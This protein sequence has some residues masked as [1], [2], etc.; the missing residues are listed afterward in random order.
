MNAMSATLD[1]GDFDPLDAFEAEKKGIWTAHVVLAD[2]RRFR[3]TFYDPA[4]LAQD[5][6]SY[7]SLDQAYVAEPGMI[8]VPEVTRERMTAAIRQ[9]ADEGYFEHLAPLTAPSTRT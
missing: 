7:Q 3:V 6:E 8:V 5:L 1:L 4:R 2:G 9:L